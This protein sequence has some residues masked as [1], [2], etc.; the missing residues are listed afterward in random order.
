MRLV[1]IHYNRILRK[2]SNVVLP[3]VRAF[4]VSLAPGPSTVPL[5]RQGSL[6]P[7][8][9][10]ALCCAGTLCSATRFVPF[11]GIERATIRTIQ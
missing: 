3:V 7:R 8:D 11:V 5:K 2:V 6:T 9:S 4:S 10:V 1:N